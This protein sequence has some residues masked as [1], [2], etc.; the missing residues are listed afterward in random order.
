MATKTITITVDA[1]KR[2]LASK[3]GKESF[4]EVVCRITGKG[5]LMKFAGILSKGTGDALETAFRQSRA[6]S[7]S[8]AEK[9]SRAFG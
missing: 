3:R 8:R 5:S 7:R 2:L 9:I 4:S 6:A 1:Y